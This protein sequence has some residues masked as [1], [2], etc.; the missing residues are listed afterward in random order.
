ML[1]I[2]VITAPITD[3]YGFQVTGSPKPKVTWNV[4]GEVVRDRTEK[5]EVN[6]TGLVIRNLK[7]QDAGYYKCKATQMEETITDF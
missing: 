2:N 6:E 4:R 3:Y 1:Y 7:L 5:Y